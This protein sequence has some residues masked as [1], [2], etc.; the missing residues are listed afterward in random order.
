M[1][2][3]GVDLIPVSRRSR[4]AS[5]ARW[6]FW[7]V[8]VGVYAAV[9]LTVTGLGYAYRHTDQSDLQTELSMLRERA[10]G[11]SAQTD[12]LRTELAST[13][14]KLGVAMEIGDRPNWSLLLRMLATQRGDGVV[15]R[16]LAVKPMAGDGEKAGVIAVSIGA[17]AK[18]QRDVMQFVTALEACG[19][20]RRVELQHITGGEGDS[21]GFAVR[22][23]LLQ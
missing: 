9:V 12:A 14:S 20:Y 3:N 10:S 17:T 6:R 11:A 18:S 5:R 8:G 4:R 21:V 19:L 7:I 15:L 13:Q 1:I 23:E 16:S 2:C 22:S